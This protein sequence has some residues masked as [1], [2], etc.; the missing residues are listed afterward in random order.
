[1]CMRDGHTRQFGTRLR[2]VETQVKRG[3][4]QAVLIPKPKPEPKP[5][6]KP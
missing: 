5:E 1:M 2:L 3:L 6:P 4:T